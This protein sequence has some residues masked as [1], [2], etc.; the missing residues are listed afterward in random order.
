MNFSSYT[1]ERLL[2]EIQQTRERLDTIRIQLESG[3]SGVDYNEMRTDM[4]RLNHLKLEAK[5]RGLT[6]E[7]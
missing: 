2:E 4:S 1:R 5:K 6:I 3:Q 7:G